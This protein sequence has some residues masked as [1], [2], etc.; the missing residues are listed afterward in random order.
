MT[1]EATT[2]PCGAVAPASIYGPD[3]VSEFRRTAQRHGER[4]FLT[5]SQSSV[6]YAEAERLSDAAAAE[7]AGWGV[8]PG[9]TEGF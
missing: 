2:P 9:D 8:A 6:T 1:P 3:I 5:D 4:P 7:F